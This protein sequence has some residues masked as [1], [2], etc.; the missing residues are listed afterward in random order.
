[1]PDHHCS[2]Y[3]IT[4]YEVSSQVLEAR[5]RPVV[6]PWA[7]GL[8]SGSAQL[9]RPPCSHP[10]S[11]SYLSI[12]DAKYQSLVLISYPSCGTRY[13]AY[14]EQ[15]S[16]LDRILQ[17]QGLPVDARVICKRMYNG[18]YSYHPTDAQLTLA[19]SMQH[20]ERLQRWVAWDRCRD[21]YVGIPDEERTIRHILPY[22]IAT[23]FA[24]PMGRVPRGARLVLHHEYSIVENICSSVLSTCD[25]ML[26]L[27]APSELTWTDCA[28]AD[29]LHIR[30]T[31]TK[32]LSAHNKA[33]SHR[34]AFQRH[35]RTMVKLRRRREPTAPVD[36]AYGFATQN[37]RGFGAT[38]T[39]HRAWL[40]S[41]GRNT[42]HGAQDVALIQKTR[43][44]I[45]EIDEIQHEY[46]ARGR[47]YRAGNGTPGLSYWGQ[48]KAGK[49][50]KWSPHMVA[51]T[52]QLDGRDLPIVN[53]YATINRWKREQ[54]FSQLST[55]QRPS[56][57]TIL[58][59]GDFNCTLH[60]H[61]DR[62]Y[63]PDASAHDSPALRLLLIVWGA[64]DCLSGSMPDR[65]A[66]QRK[67]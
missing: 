60:P 64:Q 35:K 48:R 16:A 38:E 12:S 4:D 58:L 62:T 54:P 14:R 5:L 36:R 9:I 51:I 27:R 59:G 7:A 22:V 67:S 44:G 18:C 55:F 53:I 20:W 3:H 41:L 31:I 1:M 39:A 33:T 10:R 57:G 19:A 29:M 43:V 17:D 34:A 25:W 13:E 26:T 2:H 65:E 50:D 46:E 15:V 63:G 21:T 52:G 23:W 56:H 49:E 11:E 61:L 47:E 30:S 37:V 42:P 66:A 24:T 28:A 32:G 40:Q 45:H 8:R 6:T